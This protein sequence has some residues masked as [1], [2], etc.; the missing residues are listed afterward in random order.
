MNIAQLLAALDAKAKTPKRSP[1]AP[2]AQAPKAPKVQ[3]PKAPKAQ[4][5]K[6]QASKAKPT[7]SE[8]TDFLRTLTTQVGGRVEAVRLET[9]EDALRY[10]TRPAVTSEIRASWRDSWFVTPMR[11]QRL[12]HYVGRNYRPGEGEDPEG[13]DSEGWEE[14][15]AGP[16]AR[17]A[18]AKLDARFGRGLFSVNIGEKGHID[19]ERT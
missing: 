17:E 7:S 1:R 2:K 9:L 4:A 19:V 12:D 11:R 14:E 6:A 3:T 8:V 15:Y 13:W 5:P 18:Q 16:L 10:E